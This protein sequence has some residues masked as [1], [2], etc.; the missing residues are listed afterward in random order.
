MSCVVYG[1]RVADAH[2][3]ETAGPAG[4][5]PHGAGPLCLACGLPRGTYEWERANDVHSA[6]AGHDLGSGACVQ[7]C[8]AGFEW[9]DVR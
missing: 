2:A 4:R 7:E 6:Q 1:E 5:W 3:W 9:W 8:G